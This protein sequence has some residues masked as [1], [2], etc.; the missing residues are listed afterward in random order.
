MVRRAL[1]IGVVPD[2]LKWN[3]M[4]LNDNYHFAL[5]FSFYISFSL[6]LAVSPSRSVSIRLAFSMVRWFPDGGTHRIMNSF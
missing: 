2:L 1:S 4:E 6:F 5:Y 3:K